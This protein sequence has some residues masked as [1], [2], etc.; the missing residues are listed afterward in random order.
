MLLAVL[1]RG[2]V[3]LAWVWAASI[4]AAAFAAGRAHAGSPSSV[5]AAAV[6]AAA[7]FLCHQRPERSFHLW[8]AQLPVCARCT[9]IY[10]GAVCTTLVRARRIRR[11]LPFLLAASAPAAMTLVYEWST[12]TVPG[13]WV[14]AISGL[15]IGAAVMVLLRGELGTSEVN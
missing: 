1:R 12:G 10:V 4:P 5:L 9:G 7:S 6:Y 15:A 8:A 14:R 11:P 13:N 2:L 3:P